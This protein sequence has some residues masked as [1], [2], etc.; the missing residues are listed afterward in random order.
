MAAETLQNLPGIRAETAYDTIVIRQVDA[1]LEPSRSG[2]ILVFAQQELQ[3][4]LLD[5][6]S[7]A[8]IEIP[9]ITN[10]IED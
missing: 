6:D 2:C 9:G 10:V 4:T 1:S 7:G 8:E 3:G 5:P